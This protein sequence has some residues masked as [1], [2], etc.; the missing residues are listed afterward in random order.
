MAFFS[1]TKDGL[2]SHADTMDNRGLAYGDG[3]FSTMGVHRGQILCTD[4]HTNRLKTSAERF[5]LV[6]DY[7]GVMSALTRLA[8][9]MGEG[10]IK[11]I[12]M[13]KTQSVRG[14]GYHDGQ[15][16]VWVKTMPS[17]LYDGVAM[18]A[19]I[20]CQPSGVAVC[21]SEKL[22]LRTPRFAGLKLISSHEQV[23]IH[24][25]LQQRQLQYPNLAE[26]LVQNTAGNW[27]SGTMS[28]VFYHLEGA[29]HTPSVAQSGVDGVM[30]QTLMARFGIEQRPLSTDELSLVDGL[31]FCNAVRGIMPIHTL[32]NGDERWQLVTDFLDVLKKSQ[33]S[34]SSINMV[35]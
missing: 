17:P 20:P 35:Q 28:N 7:Q 29:W 27:V 9:D 6:L 31:F 8:D 32:I 3:F 33:P 25:Q 30:R 23:F 21:L 34:K 22:S 5:E 4:G 19:G 16:C 13:R 1:F 18:Y 12:V 11:V 15:A 10:M 26:G 14:Y 24:R 2:I